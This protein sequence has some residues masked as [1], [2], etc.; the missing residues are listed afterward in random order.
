MMH[1]EITDD[2]ARALATFVAS[3]HPGW[4]VPG[5]R[6]AI[7]R[8]RHRAPAD[9]IGLA[10]IRFAMRADLTTPGLFPDDGPHWHTPGTTTATDIRF[11][12]CPVIGH[13]SYAAWNCGACK[14]DR[15]AADDSPA[16]TLRAPS[17]DQ[18]ETNARGARTVRAALNRQEQS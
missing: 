12:R 18:L 17:A 2:Q 5:V 4:D 11:T 14:A 3:L 8:A 16:D 13:G 10:A 6:A 15:L 7:S 1:G 9:E